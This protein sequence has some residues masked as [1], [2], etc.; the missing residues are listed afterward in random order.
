MKNPFHI[1]FECNCGGKSEVVFQEPGIGETLHQNFKCLHC[2]SVWQ[3]RLRGTLK[4]GR[5]DVMAAHK[6]IEP[7]RKLHDVMLKKKMDEIANRPKLKPK[8][9]FP[10]H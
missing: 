10:K 9:F 3:M 5:K 2:K 4:A 8:L 1:E 7:S 6:V